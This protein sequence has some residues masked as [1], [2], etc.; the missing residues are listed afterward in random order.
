MRNGSLAMPYL[1]RLTAG[2]ML[3]V[4]AH[5]AVF[6]HMPVQTAERVSA[7]P[8]PVSVH[9]LLLDAPTAQ[10]ATPAAQTKEPPPALVPPVSPPA[11]EKKITAKKPAAK[12]TPVR[13]KPAP[14]RS[15]PTVTP[16]L[17]RK[18][19]PPVQ[20]PVRRRPVKRAETSPPAPSLSPSFSAASV[21]PSAP[22]QAPA[23]KRPAPAPFAAPPARPAPVVSSAPPV[24]RNVSVKGKR[25]QPRYPKRALRMG[26]EGV[27]WLRALVS[28]TGETRAVN[29]YRSSGYSLLDNAALDAVKQWRFHPHVVN[30]APTESRMEVPVEFAIR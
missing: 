20:A 24:T 23:V 15:A 10:D 7:R 12:K 22:V 6:A 27:V 30:G 19:P 13:P 26:I 29:I 2:V 21:K 28:A 11:P 4:A 14:V 25:V 18:P 5:I 9:M 8:A 3:A 16:G 17:V 1:Y